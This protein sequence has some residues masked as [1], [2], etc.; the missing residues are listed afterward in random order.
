MSLDNILLGILRNP[1]SGYDIKQQFDQV[2]SHFWAA[3]LPQ[4]YRTLNRMERD[5]LVSVTREPSDRGPDRRVHQL[6][7]A[8]KEALRSWLTS[9]PTLATERIGY[10]AQT[11][12]QGA[13]EDDRAA[14]EFMRRLRGELERELGVLQGIAKDWAAEDP[15]Y[16]DCDDRE[17]F[18]A[19]LTLDLGIQKLTTKVAWA[20]RSI[21]RIEHRM[22]EGHDALVA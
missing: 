9:A 10:L 22:T 8:G 11:Y 7:P 3:D 2:F 17:A 15:S 6:T 16:P 4:I 18:Y 12:F 13:L 20:S 5:G 21:R 14:L 1:A 19:Q